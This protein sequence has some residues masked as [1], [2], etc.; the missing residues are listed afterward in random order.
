[1][2]AP[3]DYLT[4]TEVVIVPCWQTHIFPVPPVF[5]VELGHF[6]KYHS[7]KEVLKLSHWAG[8]LSLKCCH[9]ANQNWLLLQMVMT[10]KIRK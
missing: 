7:R 1:M 5:E 3:V 6:P 8:I 10:Y 9:Q 2:H 4:E